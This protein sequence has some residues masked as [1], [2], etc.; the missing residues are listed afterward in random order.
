MNS[1][2]ENRLPEKRRFPRSKIGVQLSEPVLICYRVLRR[3]ETEGA[4]VLHFFEDRIERQTAEGV[5]TGV[6]KTPLPFAPYMLHLLEN[7][8]TAADSVE[9]V[10]GD[11]LKELKLNLKLAPKSDR[12]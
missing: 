2:L 6:L 11:G 9:G 1:P 4:T 7:D 10:F 5:K 12:V 8:P 3:C